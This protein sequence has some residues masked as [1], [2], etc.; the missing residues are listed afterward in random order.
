MGQAIVTATGAEALPLAPAQLL[1]V[2]PGEVRA[3]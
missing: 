3:A 1:L 2:T